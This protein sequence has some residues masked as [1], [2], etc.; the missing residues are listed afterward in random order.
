MRTLGYFIIGFLPVLLL[1]LYRRRRRSVVSSLLLWKSVPSRKSSYPRR[2][3]QTLSL[4]L[5]G[6]FLLFLSLA[7]A[8]DGRVTHGEESE[9]AILLVETGAHAGDRRVGSEARLLELKNR[10]REK[11]ASSRESSRF[12]LIELRNPPRLLTAGP[13]DRSGVERLLDELE[14]HDTT[15][16]PE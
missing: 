7:L 16:H 1:Y 5:H 2:L 6:A 4:I 3:R 12:T 10:V 9:L 13:A 11:L 15:S 14:P 8:F